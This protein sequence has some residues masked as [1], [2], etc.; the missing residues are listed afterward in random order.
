MDMDKDVSYYRSIFFVEDEDLERLR[1]IGEQITDEQSACFQKIYD[2]M[3]QHTYFKDYYNEDVQ[4]AI[5]DNEDIFWEDLVF[6]AMDDDYIERQSYFGEVFASVGIPFNAYLAFLNRLHENVRNIFRERELM[7]LD[8]S[9]SFNKVAGIAVSTVTDGYNNSANQILQE[10]T[11]AIMEMATP[12]TQLWDGILLLPLVGY[13]DSN[14]AKTI[15]TTILEQIST[16]QSKVFILD[17]SGVAVV[18]TAVANYLMKMTQATKLMGCACVIAGIS[19][20]VARTII[21]LGVDLG[22]VE[23]KGNLMGALH[24]ALQTMSNKIVKVG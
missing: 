20:A 5:Q 16:T 7:N 24:F 6:A 21:D 19:P 8:L 4:Q 9:E 11:Q 2:W 23:T 14:R 1:T 18:D 17:I 12:V 15:M 10:Q 22:G 3:D 13:V